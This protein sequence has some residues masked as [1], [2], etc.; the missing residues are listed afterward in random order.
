MVVATAPVQSSAWTGRHVAQAIARAGAA[1]AP[2]PTPGALI[3]PNWGRAENSLQPVGTLRESRVLSAPT[4]T[5]L[6]KMWGIAGA[7]KA[8]GPAGGAAG[9]A[10]AGGAGADIQSVDYPLRRPKLERK[11]SLLD[12]PVRHEFWAHAAHEARDML[13]KSQRHEQT[14]KRFWQ[15]LA[16]CQRWCTSEAV[17]C[18]S[19]PKLCVC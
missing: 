12:V 11:G 8:G 7:T 5:H 19:P 18:C 15:V 2:S 16:D 14:T 3:Q 9:G 6:E 13:R 4:M 1:M 10:P 17:C